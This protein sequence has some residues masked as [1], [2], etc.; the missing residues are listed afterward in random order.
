MNQKEI[1]KLKE[2]LDDLFL[3]SDN[4]TCYNAILISQMNYDEK[5]AYIEKSL[6]ISFTP[7]IPSNI[8]GEVF[9]HEKR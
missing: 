2:V 5:M 1:D 9:H 7:E 4:L 8:A 6:G 3:V